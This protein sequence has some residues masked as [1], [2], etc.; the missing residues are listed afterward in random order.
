MWANGETQAEISSAA[1]PDCTG[2]M[3]ALID[4]M[5]GFIKLLIVDIMTFWDA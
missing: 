1:A 4:E 5:S 3:Q 2:E